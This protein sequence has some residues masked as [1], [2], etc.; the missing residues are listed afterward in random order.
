MFS[1]QTLDTMLA[2][3]QMWASEE[4][5]S[6]IEDHLRSIERLRRQK[7]LLDK[8]IAQ[9]KAA[10]VKAKKQRKEWDKA[11]RQNMKRMKKMPPFPIGGPVTAVAAKMG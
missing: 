10:Q 2:A 9:Y 5:E 11:A 3:V 6:K 7:R 8:I 4:L 1:D